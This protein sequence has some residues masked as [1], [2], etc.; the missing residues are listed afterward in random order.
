MPARL[1]NTAVTITVG[2]PAGSIKPLLGVNAGPSPSG[3]RE[4]PDVTGQYRQA[5]VASVRTHDLYGPLD[6][7]AIYPDIAAPPEK[8]ASYYFSDSDSA[9]RAIVGG[10]FEPYLRLGDS[11]NNVRIPRGAPQTENLARAA[12]E[13]VRHYRDDPWSVHN[14][15]WRYVEVW[16]EPDLAHFWPP[17][18][19]DSLP[20]LARTIGLVKERF[21]DLKVGGPGFVVST[22]K[23]PDRRRLV[24]LY[25]D[26]L[27]RH[28]VRPDFISFHL[29]S[30]D[31]AEYYQAALFYREAC[32]RAGW[33]NA[34]VHITEWNAEQQAVEYRLG[35][36]AAAVSTACWIAL[37]RA[38]VDA[39]FF[40]RG[41]DTDLRQPDFFGMLFADGRPKPQGKAFR[42]WSR[43]CRAA[44]RLAADTGV[45]LIDSEP[46]AD[47]E[48]SPLWLLAGREPDGK[49]MLL[50]ANI[51]EQEFDCRI[52]APEPPASLAVTEIRNPGAEIVTSSRA[53]KEFKIPPLS[54]M[55][56][57]Y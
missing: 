56:V 26:Y 44:G 27:N 37:Q 13:V 43:F 15:S 32:R 5:G 6:L 10:G 11:F 24:G 18:F 42:L 2:G 30:Q 23:L 20:F 54:V 35:K 8:A 48:L 57:E 22:Y 3:E 31:P 46:T 17:G 1:E 39:S 41:N 49:T 4:N 36:R 28:G 34:E 47:G 38:G 51:G 45:G 25:C 7:S 53:G 21:P 40:Y 16:N 19:E 29:Y 55:L 9:F 52:R 33:K 12:A 50:L 14:P